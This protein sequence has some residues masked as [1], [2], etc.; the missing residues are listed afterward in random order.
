MLFWKKNYIAFQHP[1]ISTYPISTPPHFNS[2]T[3]FATE[4]R[5]Y[6]FPI[7]IC[8]SKIT[9]RWSKK[10]MFFIGFGEHGFRVMSV[11]P[12]VR[13][14]VCL[15]RFSDSLKSYSENFEKSSDSDSLKLYSENF[16]KST[17]SKPK[18]KLK[19]NVSW[20][21]QTTPSF[22]SSMIV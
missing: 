22:R 16:E 20:K 19:E 21:F 1:K 3:I 14:S 10:S 17:F 6:F 7:L 2:R 9:F 12:C 8:M 15:C 13:V 5:F 4:G 18:G 11:C